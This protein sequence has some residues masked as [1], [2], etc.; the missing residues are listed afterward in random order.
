VPTRPKVLA[1]DVAVAEDGTARSALGGSPLAAEEEWKAEHL[2]LAGLV[3]CTL[4]SLE[5]QTRRAG[6]EMT[7]SGSAHG[8]VTRRDEDGMYAFV[9]VEAAFDIALA[10]APGAVSARELVEQ[11][12]RGCFVANSLRVRTRARWVVNGEEIA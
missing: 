12:E 7:G 11:A 3:R 9:E 1:F 4:A 2:V 6:L 8:V 10:P 5:H